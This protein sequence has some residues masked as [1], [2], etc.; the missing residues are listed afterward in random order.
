VFKH[1]ALVDVID[2]KG[3]AL[4]ITTYSN[5]MK[6]YASSLLETATMFFQ[7]PE[8]AC[9]KYGEALFQAV[10][11]SYPGAFRQEVI[12]SIVTHAG[13]GS[14]SEGTAALNLLKFLTIQEPSNVAPFLPFVKGILDFVDCLSNLHIRILFQ[15]LSFIAVCQ[16][17]T[18]A[19]IDDE[20]HICL[21]KMI[22]SPKF[23]TKKQ[24][25]LGC[26]SMA[27]A[28]SMS[29]TSSLLLPEQLR[30][31]SKLPVARSVEHVK[32]GISLLNTVVSCC[33]RMNSKGQEFLPWFYDELSSQISGHRMHGLL[34]TFINENLVQVKKIPFALSRAHAHNLN[35]YHC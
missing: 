35:I 33:S 1:K 11:Q 25:I 29:D 12:S 22:S 26:V 32:C 13:S 10:F 7:C 21:R 30:C 24:G 28:L 3:L 6:E 2:P 18:Y 15:A 5:A 16:T 27:C 9:I 23:K 31:L 34:I 14:A 8:A 17:D 4:C 20:L 19:T